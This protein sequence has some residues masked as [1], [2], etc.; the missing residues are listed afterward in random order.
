LWLKNR[1]SALLV[2]CL[3]R[4][5]YIPRALIGGFSVT[6]KAAM[7][8]KQTLLTYFVRIGFV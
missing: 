4:L 7:E 6:T 3:E 5:N 2:I 1:H 8:D